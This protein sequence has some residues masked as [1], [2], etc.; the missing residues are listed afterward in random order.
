MNIDLTSIIVVIIAAA[1][2]AQ[3]ATV[4]SLHAFTI[5]AL[6]ITGVSPPSQIWI[7][8]P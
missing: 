7:R 8:G 6:V 3:M 5:L 2:A 4:P 1:I